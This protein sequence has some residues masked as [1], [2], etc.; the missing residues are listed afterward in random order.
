MLAGAWLRLPARQHRHEP[1]AAGREGAGGWQAGQGARACCCALAPC[2][3]NLSQAPPCCSAHRL[4][5]WRRAASPRWCRQRCPRT[6]CHSC[7]IVACCTAR[8]G[9]GICATP[10][11]VATKACGGASGAG[12]AASHGRSLWEAVCMCACVLPPP[13]KATL[14]AVS[15]PRLAISTCYPPRA[16]PHPLLPCLAPSARPA[17]A[18]AP[19]LPFLLLIVLPPP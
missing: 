19:G 10:H 8:S 9:P 17:P 7:H 1:A 4:R 12:G 13:T 14:L 16:N 2:A 18:P 15:S 5:A 3:H 11:G 6:A